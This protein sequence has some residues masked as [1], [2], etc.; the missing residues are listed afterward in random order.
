MTHRHYGLRG[1]KPPE[2]DTRLR[3]AGAWSGR[4]I[5]IGVVV[6]LMLLGALLY[7]LGTNVNDVANTSA[8]A[9]HIT[10]KGAA[11]TPSAR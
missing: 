9:S 11:A 5:V 4:T 2:N 3:S 10:G 7:R 6:G 1:T 8:S